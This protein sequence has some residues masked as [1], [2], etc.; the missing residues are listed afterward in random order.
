MKRVKLPFA[1]GFEIEFVDR[2]KAV[3]QI[4]DWSDKGTGLPIVVYGPEGCGKTSL[5]LQAVE[6]LKEREYGVIYFNPLRRRFEAEV[7]I[8]SVKQVILERVKQVTSEYEFAKLVWLAIDVAVKVLK[9]GRKRIAII[10][11]DAFQLIGVKEAAAVIKGLLEIIEHPEESYERIVAIAAT[12]EGLSRFEIGRHRWAEIRAMWNMGRKGFEELYERIPGPKPSFDDVWRL[13]GGNPDMLR[14]LYLSGWSADAVIRS[15]I[16]EKSIGP[17]FVSRWRKWL[18]EAVKDPD[19]LWAPD[20]PQELINE[21]IERNL[22]VYFM[23][24]RIEYRWVD[25]PP[26]EKDDELGIGRRVAWQTP[27]HR[28]AIKRALQEL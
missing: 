15:L 27:L 8:D 21:L 6:I 1:P 14:K 18:E 10:V 17:S 11:D 16:E 5:L 9:H 2:E 12:S 22:I 4:I 13:T 23:H 7:G 26:P 28:E 3:E 25:T 19:A 20:A 24:T